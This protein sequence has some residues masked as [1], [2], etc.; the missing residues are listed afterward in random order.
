[1][2]EDTTASG[3]LSPTV[4]AAA[5]SVDAV[6]ATDGRGAVTQWSAGAQA[7]WGWSRQE[8]LGL[9]L[10]DL[11]TADGVPRHKDGHTFDAPTQITALTV[12]DQRVG[13]LVT[14]DLG[15]EEQAPDNALTSWLFDQF[16][17]ALSITD[18][19]SRVLRSNEAMCQ[20]M[21]LS[22]EDV[23]ARLMTEA[24]PGVATA[25]DVRRVRRVVAT[26][27]PVTTERFVKVPG[28]TKAHAWATDF[29]PLR[30][31]AGRVRAVGCAAYDYSQQYG[32]RERLAL[33]SE[34]RTRIGESLDVTGTAQ[35]VIKVAVPRFAD[36]VSIHLC[37]VIFHGD[38]PAPILSGPVALRR[39]DPPPEQAGGK[40][41]APVE[42]VHPESSRIA[43]CLTADRAELLRV[44]ASEI[45]RW[46]G[47]G[48]G[49]TADLP[50]GEPHS[51]IAVPIRARGLTLGLALFLRYAPAH[52][53][54]SA[55]DLTVTEDL[56]ARAA[57]CLDN[58]RQFTRE[59]GIAEALQR[60]LLPH[61]S[62]SHSAV[63]T[64]AR[65]LPAGAG[66]EVGGDWFDVIPLPGARVGLVVG[67]VV[68]HGLTASAAMGQLRTAVRT[69]ADIDL[70]P[71]ELLTHLDDVV[72]HATNETCTD[73]L[74]GAV[75]ATC[76]YV[77]YDPAARVCSMAAAGHPLPILVRPGGK[78]EVV[79]LAVGP[80]LGLGSLPFEA[81]EVAVPDGS[82]LALFTDGLIESRD[83]DVDARLDELKA[84][85]GRPSASLESMC[86]AV[87]DT[88]H[89]R[90]TSDDVALLMARTRGLDN[91]Q[92]AE[93]ELNSDPAVV[94]GTRRQVDDQLSAWGLE[95]ATFTTELVVSELVTNA[96]RYGSGPIRLRL[97]K[98]RSLICEV[99]D[100]S[101]TAP[102]L[103]R[104]RLHD[105][106][107]RGLFLVA[108]L[109]E[110]WGTR[111]TPTGKIIWAEQALGARELAWE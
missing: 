110:R 26:G 84:V 60:T 13:F 33:M 22:E 15:A 94:A 92:V 96:I 61:G 25:E 7:L 73:A 32:S 79:D 103:R 14:A 86:D 12:E 70:P 19:E 55:D 20:L 72:T 57:I 6:L 9:E 78:A 44:G 88:L 37:E 87:L 101:T 64:T 67:D 5:R 50:R 102:H 100:G 24:G 99:S 105:E 30:D 85:L 97:I 58:A 21:G 52:E 27:E 81:T 8:A 45:D 49:P 4:L 31:S 77:V 53:P 11:Y 75:G 39:A 17:L 28:E 111:Y 82:V 108:R 1:M 10:A 18:G 66:A 95:E 68:G 90:P 23:R 109:T 107:G 62:T 89:S 69:L 35:E 43:R 41:A 38:L 29:F 48:S 93:W 59:H 65:Y 104:A 36:A 40:P 74:P 56:I 2:T 98:D 54:F 46:F 91:G 34:A 106:G 42:T 83:Q 51:L 76:L 3:R 80:P 71:D 63:E 16:P 47:D